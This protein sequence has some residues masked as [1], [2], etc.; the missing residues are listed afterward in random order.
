MNR[1]GEL[2]ARRAAAVIGVSE[3]TLRRWCEAGKVQHRHDRMTNR[4]YVF[5]A[6]VERLRLGDPRHDA[7]DYF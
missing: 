7:A 5:I 1:P 4:Y 3:K 2:S 6:D